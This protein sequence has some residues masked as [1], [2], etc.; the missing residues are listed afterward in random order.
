VTLEEALERR[1]MA[2]PRPLCRALLKT[3]RGRD[4]HAYEEAVRRY[5]EEVG[6]IDETAG[7]RAARAWLE[8]GTWLGA[9]LEPGRT[10]T[11]DREGRATELRGDPPA[12]ALVLRLPQ[13]R[14][15]RALVTA[16]PRDPSPAQ[17]ATRELLAG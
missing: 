8:Y 1:E 4:A 12:G 15:H 17:G 13:D 5:E 14:R 3:L 6:S 9:C 16:A 7:E 11:V 2:D 10:V